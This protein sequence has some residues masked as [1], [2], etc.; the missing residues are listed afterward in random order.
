MRVLTEGMMREGKQRERGRGRWIN[1]GMRG[2]ERGLEGL[3]K[4][5]AKKGGRWDK[6]VRKDNGD[7]KGLA[8]KGGRWDEWERK[9]GGG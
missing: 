6:W 4:E 5:R 1:V 2:D 3:R 9:D 7:E 8:E